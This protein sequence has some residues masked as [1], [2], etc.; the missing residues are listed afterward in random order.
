MELQDFYRAQVTAD[1]LCD[2][3]ACIYSAGAQ[4]QSK[5]VCDKKSSVT[6]NSTDKVSE[7]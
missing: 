4:Q 5:F 7:M 6:S 2:H 3:L 1:A